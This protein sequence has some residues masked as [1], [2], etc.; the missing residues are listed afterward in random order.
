MNGK[1]LIDTLTKLKQNNMD[2]QCY[3]FVSCLS[4]DTQ[5]ELIDEK[6]DDEIISILIPKFRIDAV[7]YFFKVDNRANYLFKNF[8]IFL[9]EI[10]PTSCPI[11][12]N[13]K[14]ALSCLKSSL[15]SALEVIIL[16]GSFV[17]FVTISSINTPI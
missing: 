13:L 10:N 9:S 7:N 5:K 14:S 4:L 2:T 6:L 17:P 16:Y 12:V 1:L 15:Y 8:D 3:D 11:S